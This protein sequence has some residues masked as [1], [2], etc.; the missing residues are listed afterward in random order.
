MN[1]VDQDREYREEI[2]GNNS[3]TKPYWI[4]EEITGVWFILRN[5]SDMNKEVITGDPLRV[6]DLPY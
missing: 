6:I 1:S 4:T 3:I 2:L 5:L